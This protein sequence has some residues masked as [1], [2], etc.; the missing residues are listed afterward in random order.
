MD[1]CKNARGLNRRRRIWLNKQY[2][3]AVYMNDHAPNERKLFRTTLYWAQYRKRQNSKPNSGRY[4][5]R[6]ILRLIF[7]GVGEAQVYEAKSWYL[8]TGY[9]TPIPLKTGETLRPIL[10]ATNRTVAEVANPALSRQI[11]FLQRKKGDTLC[12][13]MNEKR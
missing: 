12:K 8:G 4:L 13:R 9:A 10:K 5:E 7:E 2:N 3:Y 11:Y 6:E 1:L